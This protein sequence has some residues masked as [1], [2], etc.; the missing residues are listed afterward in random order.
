MKFLRSAIQSYIDDGFV[1]CRKNPT[2]ELYIYN[3]TN[4]CQFERKWDNI[5]MQC[6]GLVL[7]NQDN[8]IARPF[9]KFLNMEE[10][11]SEIPKESFEVTSKEDGS[12][13]IIFY[14]NNQW[15]IATRGSFESEQ[16]I[17]G[18]TLLDYLDLS[19]LDKEYTYLAEIICQSSRVVVNYH[20]QRKLIFITR[21]NTE[22]GI[23]SSYEELKENLGDGFEIVERFD[24]IKDF[25]KLTENNIENKEGFVIHF[26][27]ESNLRL[28][29]KFSDYVRLHRIITGITARRIWDCLRMQTNMKEITENVPEEFSTWVKSITKELGEKFAS[30]MSQTKRDYKSVIESLEVEAP[31]D[32]VIG[33]KLNWNDFIKIDRTFKKKLNELFLEKENPDILNAIHN[34]MKKKKIVE[35]VWKKLRPAHELPFIKNNE[36]EE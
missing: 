19:R 8:I 4:H 9:R 3:Y 11:T 21:I 13:G 30:I 24:G 17:D 33:Y 22:T 26:L 35:M 6:R 29:A 15:N 23:E 2:K 28:K 25:T 36:E 7:D 32:M 20:G 1:S 34:N 5:T 27:G 31:M 18:K 10:Y 16:A 14:Y 12:L